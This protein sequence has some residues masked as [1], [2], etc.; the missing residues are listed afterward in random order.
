MME[1]EA[2]TN[3]S[4]SRLLCLEEEK[5]KSPMSFGQRRMPRGI[6]QVPP[7]KVICTRFERC[8]DCPY[9][10]HGFLCWSKDGECLRDAVRRIEHLHI[11]KLPE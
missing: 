2:V 4:L 11:Q 7:E 5:W 6:R 3:C 9:P 10:G 1:R 8:R